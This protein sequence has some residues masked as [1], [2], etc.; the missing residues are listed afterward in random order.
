MFAVSLVLAMGNMF[1]AAQAA[2][3]PI[4]HVIVIMQ[5]NRSFDQY[6]GTFPGA[7]GI[8]PDTCVPLD[9]AKPSLGCVRP[10]HDP[11]DVNA[12]GPHLAASAQ[13]DLDDGITADKMDGF[14][15]QQS[16]AKTGCAPNA[17]ACSANGNGVSRHDVVGYHTQDEIYNY[18]AYAKHFVLQDRLFEGV[19]SWSYPE[20]LDLTSEWSASCKDYSK[21]STCFTDPNPAS[22]T[23][24]T[25]LPWVSLFQLL[26]VKGVSWKYYLGTG[27]EPDCEDGE[28]TCEPQVQ[29]HGVPSIWNPAPY[30][31]WVK[32]KGPKYLQ[33]HNPDVD[34]LLL[35]VKNGTLPQVSWVVPSDTY[36]EHPPAGVTRGM[37]YVTSM[38]NAV[39]RS[40]YWKN[41]VIFIA[42][43][44]WGGFYDH[45]VPP[46]VDRNGTNTPIEGF[47]LRVA[48]LTVSAYAKAGTIDH[49]MLSLDSYATFIEDL[50]MNG[51]RLNPTAL[52]NPDKRPA[53]RDAL[54]R[55]K[56]PDGSTE[57][58]GNLM[59]EFDFNQS[60]L[61][62]L[63]LSTSIPTGIMASCGTGANKGERCPQP[64]VTIT[65]A[66]VTGKQVHGPFIYHVRRD[67]VELPQCASRRT[68]CMDSNPGSGVH[69]YRAYSVGP[70]GIA[71][72]LSAASEVDVP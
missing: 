1:S 58:I 20:H 2:S 48:G 19:R 61:H 57:P 31:A 32:A 71:S 45:V 43:D 11:H 8:P 55:V 66:A 25:N 54:T 37:E 67:G 41:T 3:I 68:T 5:E 10:F 29:T 18:W 30:F 42:W 7:D 53:I 72:P 69:L 36:S 49:Q 17:P 40:P 39:M 59:N 28:M 33:E 56:F 14:I 23:T 51:A 63:V 16:I 44:D 4:R 62:P 13:A 34:R 9:P 12:G 70:K 64:P 60:P 35:D 15:H 21:A 52:G 27:T 50:F 24:G 65:W 22:P 46:N 38:V 47:G 26:D 6:F